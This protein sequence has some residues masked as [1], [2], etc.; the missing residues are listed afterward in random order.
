MKLNILLRTA[1]LLLMG[2]TQSSH[3]VRALTPLSD[4]TLQNIPF[5]GLDF[6]IHNKEG[7][8]API[9]IPRVAGTEGS[10]KVRD[11]FAHFF[12]TQ[13]PKWNIEYQN[14]TSKTPVHGN[15]EVPFINMIM[16]RDPPWATP[17]NIGRLTLV[18]HYDS[19]LEPKGFIGAIDSAAPCAMLLHAARTLDEALTRKWDAM[20]AA[21][22]DGLEE[23]VGIQILLLD[24]EEAMKDWNAEDSLYGARSLAAEWE[25]TPH[26]ANS[27]Y[28]TRL[29]EISLFVLLDLLGSSDPVIPSYWS[30][31]HW[32]YKNMAKL[33]QRLRKAPV[34]AMK[35]KPKRPFLV[36]AEK[37]DNRWAGPYMQDDHVP[38]LQRGVEVLHLIPS[39]FPKVWHRME[40][41]G[42]H[43]DL[44]TVEDWAKLTIAFAAEWMELEGHFPPPKSGLMERGE[45]EDEKTEL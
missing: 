8:L 25:N 43:L 15:K 23:D 4:T 16:T 14:S 38:F 9:L 36:D 44:D 41:D 45:G 3:S 11:H 19:K 7:L 5:A 39:P 34:Q 17:G 42:E 35:S 2:C 1:A 33:E 21:G 32:A 18:A 29:S 31:T 6:D 30:S 24:G 37:K 22:D 26:I 12:T 10:K 28:R 27:R 20:I 40:D 13:L